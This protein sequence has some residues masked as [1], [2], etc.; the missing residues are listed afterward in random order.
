MACGI[1]A[2]IM[3]H[4]MRGDH[5]PVSLDSVAVGVNM[6]RSIAESVIYVS[7]T[8][9]KLRRNLIVGTVDYTD[10]FLIIGSALELA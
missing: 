9:E 8:G 2:S 10:A 6:A 5:A 1:I 3:A 7:N 4:A